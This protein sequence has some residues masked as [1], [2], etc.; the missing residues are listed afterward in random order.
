MPCCEELPESEWRH[1]LPNLDNE[2]VLR[3]E[4][5]RCSFSYREMELINLMLEDETENNVEHKSG[6]RKAIEFLAIIILVMAPAVPLIVTN[7]NRI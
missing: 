5:A 1:K 7:I 6:V 3:E 4:A 2:H